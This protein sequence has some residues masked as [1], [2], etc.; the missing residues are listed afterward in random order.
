MPALTDQQQRFVHHLVSSGSSPTEAARAAG[1]AVPKQ[2]AYR[3][4]HLAHI[5]AAIKSERERLISAH[6]ANLALTT[7][8]A[9]M[10]D[11]AAPASARVG[12]S[13]TML[14]VAG[15]FDKA[16]RDLASGKSMAEMSADDLQATVIKLDEHLARLAGSTTIN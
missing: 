13:R 12:A 11:Q 2:E 1:Y 8:M 16:G 9:I 4:T 7:L 5:Q 6:G 14:E 15:L 10:K 3:L